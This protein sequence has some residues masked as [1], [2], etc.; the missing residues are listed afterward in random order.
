MEVSEL[1]KVSFEQVERQLRDRNFGVLGTVSMDY[2]PHS[3]GVV[4]GVSRPADPLSF[5]ATTRKDNKK[6]RN[7]RA[8]ANVSFVVPLSRRLLTFVPPCCIQFQ[9]TADILEASNEKAIGVFQSSRFLQVI[10]Q[11]ELEIVSRAGGEA[12]FIC[13]VPD[14]TIFTYGLGIPVW[15]LR[16]KADSA[17]SKVSI[18]AERLTRHATQSG[19]VTKG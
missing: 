13:I 11:T 14:P 2:R 5:Y 6:V 19:P 16:A 8:N 1:G 3:T 18:P 17:M 12:C 10:L 9:A 7:L 4:Y 15:R